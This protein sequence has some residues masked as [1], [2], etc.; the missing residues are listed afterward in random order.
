MCNALLAY[1]DIQ[2]VGS[3]DNGLLAT[4]AGGYE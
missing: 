1:E 2:R 3:V 4:Y